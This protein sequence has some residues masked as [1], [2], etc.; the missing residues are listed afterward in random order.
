MATMAGEESRGG[1]TNTTHY[2]WL[3]GRQ[4]VWAIRPTATILRVFR[5][6]PGHQGMGGG[7]G[8]HGRGSGGAWEG[9]RGGHGRGMGG[10]EGGNARGMG[11]GEG[12]HG[13]GMGGRGGAWEGERGGMGGAWEGERGGMGGAWEGRGNASCA[14]RAINPKSQK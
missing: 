1:T 7:E 14:P 12:G 8:G 2:D 5:L 11:G 3:Q 4:C 10:G 9:E 6:L 13:R